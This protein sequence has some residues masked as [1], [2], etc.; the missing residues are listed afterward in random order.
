MS[1]HSLVVLEEIVLKELEFKMHYSGPI[2][3]LERFVKLFR[4]DE[5]QDNLIG[6]QINSAAK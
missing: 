4:L 5:W 1:K 2:P 6:Q 3:F